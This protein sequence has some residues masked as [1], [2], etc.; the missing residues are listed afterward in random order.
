[1]AFKIIEASDLSGKGVIGQSDSPG[2]S[3]AAMQAKVEEV[4]RY[5][6][7]VM[8]DNFE[9]AYTQTETDGQIAQAVFDSG[10]AD[11]TKY[12][13]VEP[14]TSLIKDTCV[15]KATQA[16]AEAGTSNLV[17]MTPLL[18]K[19]LLG[20]YD[21]PRRKATYIYT[22][23]DATH[24]TAAI[25]D[26]IA[27][28]EILEIPVPEATYNSVAV[29][30]VTIAIAFGTPKDGYENV[31]QV[32]LNTGTVV[33]TFSWPSGLKWASAFSAAASKSYEVNTSYGLS[34]YKAAWAVFA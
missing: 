26:T 30:A 7:G 9:Q 21:R 23:V 8:N 22:T 27:V 28:N 14:G 15:P 16:D 31:Y 25:N 32:Y 11:M 29:T 17:F 5:A 12:E 2:L 34:E 20:K 33:P 1:M 6:I 4:A 24:V 10:A 13:F 18:V 3:A 19:G